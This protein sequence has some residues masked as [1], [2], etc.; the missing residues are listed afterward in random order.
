MRSLRAAVVMGL[1]S[2]ALADNPIPNMDLTV[3]ESGSW[4][5]VV[6]NQTSM[7]LMTIPKANAFKL[8][9]LSNVDMTGYGS[10]D[11]VE[12]SD[13]FDMVITV[14]NNSSPGVNIHRGIVTLGGLWLQDNIAYR[15]FESF[16]QAGTLMTV[17]VDSDDNC[18]FDAYPTVGRHHMYPGAYSPVLSFT[19]N[20]NDTT[21]PPSP[22]T[23]PTHSYAVSISTLY[24]FQDY[25]HV[26]GARIQQ[27][28]GA[29][30]G[31][32]K[33]MTEPGNAN[34]T[35]LNEFN[36]SNAHPDHVIASGMVPAGQTRT[37]TIAVRITRTDRGLPANWWMRTLEPYRQAFRAEYGDVDYVHDP[38]PVRP[39]VMA[40][41]SICDPVTNPNGYEPW[42]DVEIHG[43]EP[44][45]E[46]LDAAACNYGYSRQMVWA[47]TGVYCET[48]GN[49]PFL[50]TSRWQDYPNAVLTMNDLANWGSSNDL[51][52]YWGYAATVH[53]QW[54]PT[55][56]VNIDPTVPNAFD[57]AER[58]LD[59]AIAVNA[60]HIGLDAFQQLP[61]HMLEILTHYIDYYY[62]NA[63]YNPK[64]IVEASAC[65][66]LHRL[67]ASYVL[68]GNLGW[69]PQP[70]MMS[71]YLLPGSETWYAINETSP[72][73]EEARLEL[74]EGLANRGFNFLDVRRRYA[75]NGTFSST[76]PCVTDPVIEADPCAPADAKYNADEVWR[77]LIPISIRRVS[78]CDVVFDNYVRILSSEW[79]ADTVGYTNSF[80]SADYHSFITDFFNGDPNADIA[81]DDMTP[82]PPFGYSTSANS[83]VNSSDYYLFLSCW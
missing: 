18:A 10:V 82:L 34:W 5:T 72:C 66:F 77:T 15:N 16:A 48:A 25:D 2:T 26:T 63:G 7:T 9:S 6:D 81:Y 13:G 59:G 11:Y 65:D 45:I 79:T 3:T 41:I 80:N 32:P 75:L 38:R 1:A 64:F 55:T 67:A 29:L 69:T 21:S 51:G 53:N 43:F 33:C 61:Q 62:I 50:F 28:A 27:S 52:L 39:T 37:Y 60:N 24:D 46:D 19:N 30:P 17:D 57:E 70:H 54:N 40:A 83:G 4:V 44:M 23:P 20:L 73:D 49:Y 71:H 31:A 22:Y 56:F 76:N 42:R 12:R 14:N 36:V 74:L 58:E 68:A 78:P 8:Y 35:Y 47:A